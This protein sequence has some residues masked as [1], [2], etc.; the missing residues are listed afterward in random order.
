[1]TT[2]EAI[3]WL[4]RGLFAPKGLMTP[5]ETSCITEA[6][7]MAVLAIHDKQE[8]APTLTKEY[9][10]EAVLNEVAVTAKD[11]CPVCGYLFPTDDRADY[12]PADE[13]E[14]CYHCGAKLKGLVDDNEKT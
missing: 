13:I 10:Y 14:F 6:Y 5:E 11:T 4:Q 8:I 2:E 7:D 12:I 3:N 9:E 1:M